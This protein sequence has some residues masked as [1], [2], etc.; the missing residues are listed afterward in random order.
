MG[1]FGK[2]NKNNI[3]AEN[4]STVALKSGAE[5]NMSSL[6][7]PDDPVEFFRTQVEE[8]KQKLYY[9]EIGCKSKAAFENDVKIYENKRPYTLIAMMVNLER[10]NKVF[11]RKTGDDT[12]VTISTIFRKYFDDFY[13]I[14]G[15]KFNILGLDAEK[16]NSNMTLAVVELAKYLMANNLDLDIYYGACRTDEPELTGLTWKELIPVAVDR[17]YM[18]RA[19]KNPINEAVKEEEIANKM[20]EKELEKRKALQSELEQQSVIEE[21][22]DAELDM[23][24]ISDSLGSFFDEMEGIKAESRISKEELDAIRKEEEE[25]SAGYIP[26]FPFEEGEIMESIK[27]KYLKTMWFHMSVVEISN[28]RDFHKIKF[29]IFPLNYVAPPLTVKSL[30]VAEDVESGKRH[31]YDGTNV[32]AGIAN[33]EFYINSRFQKND[34]TGDVEFKVAITTRKDEWNI[35]SREDKAHSGICTPYHFGKTFFDKELFPIKTNMDGLCESVVR[36]PDG[37]LEENNGN[38]KHNDKRYQVVINGSFMEI[39]EV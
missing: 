19:K 18:D 27:K 5:A 11:G 29:R 25:A 15:E 34:K 10:V 2:K 13:R 1:L 36:F 38:I 22:K 21:Q 12:L 35:V 4:N 16:M 37:H 28:G 24:D 30:V 9:D 7:V 32:V 8:L 26:G 33:T 3:D 17:M 39:V 6:A 31:I 23:K 20:L 14:G